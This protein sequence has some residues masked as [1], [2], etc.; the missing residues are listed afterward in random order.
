MEWQLVADF[1]EARKEFSGTGL[2]P[3]LLRRAI[4]TEPG[5][6]PEEVLRGLSRLMIEELKWI[7]RR[8]RKIRR[9]WRKGKE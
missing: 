9:R 6:D 2:S 3:K 4:R 8:M 1:P 7:A 5:H